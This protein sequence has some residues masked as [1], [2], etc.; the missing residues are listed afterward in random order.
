[1]SLYVIYL[2]L[3]YNITKI[4]K[5]IYYLCFIEYQVDYLNKLCASAYIK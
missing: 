5:T 1:M 2:T 4:K 3:D